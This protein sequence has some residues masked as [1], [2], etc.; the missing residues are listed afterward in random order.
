MDYKP[1][2]LE[3]KRKINGF[4]LYIH[5]V[6]SSKYVVITR[7]SDHKHVAK[8]DAPYE[9]KLRSLYRVF[10]IFGT[11]RMLCPEVDAEFTAE[12]I[13]DL[14]EWRIFLVKNS[15]GNYGLFCP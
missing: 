4:G 8:F 7:A 1:P 12:R 5:H 6:G 10:E 15:R 11:R 13:N 14:K 3:Y 9:G 2:I